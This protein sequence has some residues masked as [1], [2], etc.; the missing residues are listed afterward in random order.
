MYSLVFGGYLKK[1]SFLG[2]GSFTQLVMSSHQTLS[3]DVDLTS[4]DL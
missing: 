4:S 2:Y 3:L 1:Q